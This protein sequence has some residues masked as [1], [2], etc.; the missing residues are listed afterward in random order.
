MQKTVRRWIQFVEGYANRWWYSPLIAV[1]AFADSFIVVVPTDGLLVSAAMLAPRRWVSTTIFVSL[2]SS[3]GALGL[4]YLL[5]RQGLPWLLYFQPDIQS[6]RAW[7]YTDRL[8]DAWGS[9]AIFVISLTP[10]MQQP[11]VALAALAGRPMAE[12]FAA[13]FAGRLI[14]YGLLAWVS[15]HAPGVLGKLWGFK[16]DLEEAGVKATPDGKVVVEVPPP[17]PAAHLPGSPRE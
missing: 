4:A 1:L 12:I 17:H 7:I 5:A 11:A 10:I 9:W 14:K 6:S 15:T 13:A 3:L 8:M 16:S 2:G